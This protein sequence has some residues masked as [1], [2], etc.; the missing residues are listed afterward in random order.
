MTNYNVISFTHPIPSVLESFQSMSCVGGGSGNSRWTYHFD[1]TVTL[2]PKSPAYVIGE[3]ILRPLIDGSFRYCRQLF[4]VVKGGLKS[5]D[6]RISNFLTP[7][8]F[9]SAAH[10]SLNQAKDTVKSDYL[11]VKPLK[12]TKVW[13]AIGVDPETIYSFIKNLSPTDKKL[14]EKDFTLNHNYQEFHAIFL[15]LAEYISKKSAEYM[16]YQ[17]TVVNVCENFRYFESDLDYILHDLQLNRE[18]SKFSPS[19][20]KAYVLIFPEYSKDFKKTTKEGGLYQIEGCLKGYP[21]KNRPQK[22]LTTQLMTAERTKIREICYDNPV[23]AALYGHLSQMGGL[24]N[25]FNVHETYTLDQFKKLFGN[26]SIEVLRKHVSLLKKN[27]NKGLGKLEHMITSYTQSLYKDS[28]DRIHGKIHQ[29]YQQH[30]EIIG[31]SSE[32]RLTVKAQ[33]QTGLV[34]NWD[35][36]SIGSSCDTLSFRFRVGEIEPVPMNNDDS[37]EHLEHIKDLI[38]LGVYIYFRG[39]G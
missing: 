24:L 26:K 5:I 31:S 36:E 18:K 19:S 35:V 17:G 14:I 29:I 3:Q 4:N 21:Q 38:L 7:F 30:H 27:L 25:I 33:T 22:L 6:Q 11:A 34:S 23:E 37:H 32:Q 12:L 28:F 13:T 10:S 1:G 9:V 8:P 2:E 15:D 20:K 16:A 39:E